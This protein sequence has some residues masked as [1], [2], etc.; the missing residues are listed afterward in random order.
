MPAAID[1]LIKKQV[2][3]Q[4]LAGDSRDKIAADN[5]IGAGTVTNIINEWKKGVQD[6]DYESVRELAVFS[7]KE[8]S[9]CRITEMKCGTGIL[10]LEGYNNF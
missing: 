1:P 4:W 7:K 5:G 10:R 6:S 9:L 8:G 3:N 2:I